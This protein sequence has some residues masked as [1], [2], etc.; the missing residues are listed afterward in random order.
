M[1]GEWIWIYG[2]NLASSTA[3]LLPQRR[4]GSQQCSASGRAHPNAAIAAAPDG[5]LF[6]QRSEYDA[7]C[8][9]EV[10]SQGWES[11]PE[12][13]EPETPFVNVLYSGIS[14]FDGGGNKLPNPSRGRRWN[15]G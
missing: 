12:E 9:Q 11:Q 5:I 15:R 1:P 7:Q 10:G 4:S 8:M 6:K 14:D 2:T 3:S 13:N